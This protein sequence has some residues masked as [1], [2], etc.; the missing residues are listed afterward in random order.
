M[1]LN[2]SI[3]SIN[4]DQQSNFRLK[5]N[6]ILG[7]YIY[8]NKFIIISNQNVPVAGPRP[9]VFTYDRLVSKVIGRQFDRNF[10]Q[11]NKCEEV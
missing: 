7:N 3:F 10:Q 1:R 9:E 8:F 5:E 11:Q 6:K 4:D 2:I